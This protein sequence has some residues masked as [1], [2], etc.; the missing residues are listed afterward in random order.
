M[1]KELI[2]EFSQLHAEPDWIF[3]L[4]QQAFDKIDQLEL[5][6]MSGLNFIAGIWVTAVFQRASR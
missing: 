5:P 1:T 3:Q 6:R 2:Q 4:R